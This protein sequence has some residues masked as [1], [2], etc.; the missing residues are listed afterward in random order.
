MVDDMAKQAMRD[1]QACAANASRC[2]A[3]SALAKEA[4]ALA[5]D[6]ER[7]DMKA[8]GERTGK[9]TGRGIS[10]WAK[11]SVTK[12]AGR[13]GG[14]AVNRSRKGIKKWIRGKKKNKKKGSSSFNSNHSNKIRKQMKKRGWTNEMI[15]EAMET[16]GVPTQG[17]KNPATRYKHPRT[18]ASVTVDEVTKEVFQV[19]EPDYK[20]DHY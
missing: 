12:G 15:Q 20:F 19:G 17:K 8:L 3:E 11:S 9:L 10:E 4:K 7:G 14:A 13:V 5:E 18:G 6:I 1:G 2:L 16:E